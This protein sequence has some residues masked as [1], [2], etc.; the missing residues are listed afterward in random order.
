M[1]FLHPVLLVSFVI[2][3]F[4]SLLISFFCFSNYTN[5]GVYKAPT[6]FSIKNSIYGD[7]STIFDLIKQK[8]YANKANT[9]YITSGDENGGSSVNIY[10]FV[11]DKNSYDKL[12]GNGFYPT[13][14]KSTPAH[15]YSIENLG[16]HKI[17]GSYF[18]TMSAL[19]VQQLCANLNSRGVQTAIGGG[20]FLTIFFYTLLM[21]N[22]YLLFIALVIGIG[23]SVIFVCIKTSKTFA[24]YRSQGFSKTKIH[25]L[26]IRKSSAGF[27]MFSVLGLVLLTAWIGIYNGFAQFDEFI[28]LCLSLILFLFCYITLIQILV[29]HIILHLI[30][31]DVYSFLK[32][33]TQNRTISALSIVTQV[34]I[35]SIVFASISTVLNNRENIQINTDTLSK[36]KNVSDYNILQISYPMVKQTSKDGDYI[37][38][39][40]GYTQKIFSALT[41]I[42]HDQNIMLILRNKA[43]LGYLSNEQA[44]EHEFQRNYY[45]KI[46]SLVVNSVFLSKSP[47]YDASNQQIKPYLDNE[48][49]LLVPVNQKENIEHIISASNEYLQS[50]FVQNDKKTNIK[51]TENQIKYTK[52]NQEIVSYNTGLD[53]NM[54]KNDKPTNSQI[55]PIILVAPNEISKAQGIYLT[56]FNASNLII[57][58]SADVKKIMNANDIG[59]LYHSFPALNESA[60]SQL[61]KINQQQNMDYAS[62]AIIFL[63]LFFL[64]LVQAMVYCLKNKQK[65]FAMRIS[66]FVISKIILKTTIKKLILLNSLL[67]VFKLLGFFNTTTSLLTALTIVLRVWLFYI[68]GLSHYIATIKVNYI[69]QR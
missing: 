17:E 44:E 6:F 28:V 53:Y 10:A 59:S 40:T 65:I 47:I 54:G 16:E 61:A 56:A 66:G 42:N 22:L 3:I 25:Y 31:N 7:T 18:T 49:H 57:K 33:M 41:E 12:F 64:I 5:F 26:F 11:G 38:A 8:T 9:Y 39:Q 52:Q 20:S 30:D 2:S 29:L 36:Y 46:N 15:I 4:G 62:F 63:V 60:I 32:G 45:H 50:E 69:K 27:A 43:N 24:I 48:Y 23:F 34:L 51:I 19:Q 67:L 58:K 68:I 35:F 14:D 55:D 1:K 21:N 13:F 37:G